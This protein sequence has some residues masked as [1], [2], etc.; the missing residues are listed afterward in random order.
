M[1]SPVRRDRFRLHRLRRRRGRD[2][3]RLAGPADDRALGHRGPG[4]VEGT[5]FE[6]SLPSSRRSDAHEPDLGLPE[7]ADHN[8]DRCAAAALDE[9]GP[10]DDDRGGAGVT[11]RTDRNAAMSA[12]SICRA[13]GR[14]SPRDRLPARNR[15]RAPASWPSACRRE[16]RHRAPWQY[17]P[18]RR[19][20]GRPDHVLRP[21]LRRPLQPGGEPRLRAPARAAVAASSSPMSLR[22]SSA[23]SS[24]PGPRI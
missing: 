5:D 10:R 6:R 17:D 19:H 16:R 22:R 14:G 3:P 23:R 15:G 9:I 18:D 8:L 12:S 4:R 1:P 21:D 20:P 24:A 7:P 13:T 2:L 11:P